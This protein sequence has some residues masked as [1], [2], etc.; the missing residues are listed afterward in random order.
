MKKIIILMVILLMSTIC[1]S[2]M[3]TGSVDTTRLN[4]VSLY[5]SQEDAA[6]TGL[7]V[8]YQWYECA[9]LCDSA[10]NVSADADMVK[11]MITKAGS[12]TYLGKY[13]GSDPGNMW[14]RKKNSETTAVPYSLLIW[15]VK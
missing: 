2:Q 10:L 7:N 15:G 11:N 8:M 5:N 14:F 12:W 13:R 3:F 4:F 6:I 1:Y 9:I